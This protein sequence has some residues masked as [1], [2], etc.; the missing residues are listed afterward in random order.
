MSLTRQKREAH[1][2]ATVSLIYNPPES[3]HLVR[4]SAIIRTQVSSEKTRATN[5]ETA[6][7]LILSRQAELLASVLRT[8][9]IMTFVAI[10]LIL[11]L[12][13]F[14]TS[15]DV[16][17][18]FLRNLV[19]IIVIIGLIYALQR[20]WVIQ[21]FVAVISFSLIITPYTVLMEAPGNMQMMAIMFLPI[22][23]AGFLPKRSQFWLVYL[24]TV[25]ITLATAWAIVVYKD[26]DIGYRSVV[27]LWM[28]MTIMALM[29]DGISSSYRQS[30]RFTFEHLQE[31]Q[32]AHARMNEINRELNQ[33]V[34]ERIRA[35]SDSTRSAQIERLALE[36]A[37]AGILKVDLISMAVEISPEILSKAAINKRPEN[38]DQLLTLMVAPD[39]EILSSAMQQILKGESRTLN[40]EF[41]LRGDGNQTWLLAAESGSPD[42]ASTRTLTG[43]L[44]DVSE[45][46]IHARRQQALNEKLKDTQKLESLGLMAGGIAHDFNNL[47]HVIVLDADIARRS[48][49]LSNAATALLDNL[50]TTADRA[51]D[52][53][54]QLLAYSGKGQFL[55]EPF[56]LEDL[57]S[58]MGKLLLVGTPSNARV[59]Y[60]LDG[61]RPVIKG[62][63]TQ[64]RQIV[65]NLITNAGE[66]IGDQAG[67]ITLGTST[68]VIEPENNRRA[69]NN[70]NL[71]PGQY[72]CIKVID[73][74]SGMNEATIEKIF[75]PFFTTKAAGRGLGLSAVLGIV[76]GHHGSISIDSIPG[77]G[78]TV[79]VL[80]P[81]S[82][83]LLESVPV[84][85]QTISLRAAGKIL[86]ADDEKDIC[87]L[88]EMVL[89]KAGYEVIT[90]ADGLEAITLFHEHQAEL[91]MAILDVMM[92][93]KTGF[94]V[95]DEIKAMRPQLPVI[96]SSGY[97]ENDAL[98]RLANH[99]A[100]TFLKKPYMADTLEKR[101]RE[102]LNGSYFN[103]TDQT[104]GYT[105]G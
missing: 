88:A 96:L 100:S 70:T 4:N 52:L 73:T 31:I 89:S 75:D 22:G 56:D 20:G 49:G 79:S 7:D 93:G 102:M 35:Q 9:A 98:Q 21:T 61:S 24:T 11:F 19:V 72:A 3:V 78:T 30:I 91:V 42:S 86:F 45:K 43:V 26:V 94:E 25:L 63:I 90:A 77:V 53:C 60:E 33:A 48:S 41:R 36:A 85:A 59:H 17:E 84:P 18:P 87:N 14:S 62:D 57:V 8:V 82:S 6:D 64:I 28:L 12:P 65:L 67:T 74:G 5:Y 66:A 76:K 92:P 97:N 80:L 29:T 83:A 1:N 46:M 15:G 13:G 81:V 37:G 27:T 2:V 40:G 71:P 101:V 104:R 68:I 16:M 32:A 95:I 39:R 47:L 44:V 23:L 54:S 50:L 103:A 10:L 34:T 58:N 38:W 51:S 105:S 69:Y 99:P 55:I